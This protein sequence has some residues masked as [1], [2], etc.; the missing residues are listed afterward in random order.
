MNILGNCYLYIFQNLNQTV[1]SFYP[2]STSRTAEHYYTT[3]GT[4]SI[5]QGGGLVMENKTA[6]QNSQETSTLQQNVSFCSEL[7]L[8]Y[9]EIYS[10]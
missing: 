8:C 7:P 1:P 3:P 2:S 9:A 10:S 5:L 6:Y 4:V